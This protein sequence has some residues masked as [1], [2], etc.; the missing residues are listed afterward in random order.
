MNFIRKY[1]S[2]IIFIVFTVLVGMLS[3]F[4]SGNIKDSLDSL[5]KPT[6]MPPNYLFP[7][8][9]TILYILMGISAAIVYDL[10]GSLFIY[11]LQL[12]F[13]FA[14]SIIFFR[15]NLFL[16]SFIWLVILIVLVIIMAYRFYKI[17]KFA[18]IL[19]IPYLLWITFA[20]YL[21]LMIYILN[22]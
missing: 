18:S 19:Q 10:K 16:F 14:W 20:G 9:W 12:F 2:Y 3:A 11:Y 13:N 4:L 17:N 8:V 7:I 5:N 1:K 6:L 15:Y 22:K 21:N